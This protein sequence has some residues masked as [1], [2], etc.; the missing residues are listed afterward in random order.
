MYSQLLDPLL[1]TALPDD[2]DLLTEIGRF[3]NEPPFIQVV[4]TLIPVTSWDTSTDISKLAIR[5]IRWLKVC[6]VPRTTWITSKTQYF[7]R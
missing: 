5:V 4:S 2:P 3:W 1:K 6:P 7:F